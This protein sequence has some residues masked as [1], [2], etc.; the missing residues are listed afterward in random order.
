[1][2]WDQAKKFLL[3]V[4]KCDYLAFIKFYT[5]QV[6]TCYG[7]FIWTIILRIYTKHLIPIVQEKLA[8]T[9]V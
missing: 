5:P 1:M 2:Q 4:Q 6:N 9:A 7:F 8:L 3:S